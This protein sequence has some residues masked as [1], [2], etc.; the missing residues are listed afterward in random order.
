MITYCKK[1]YPYD[2]N[3]ISTRLLQI[4][5]SGNTYEYV[6]KYDLK[7]KSFW[8]IVFSEKEDHLFEGLEFLDYFLPQN[9]VRRLKMTEIFKNLDS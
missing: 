4:Y 6:R 3:C 2:D 7:T 5:N 1:S 9:V 8:Y